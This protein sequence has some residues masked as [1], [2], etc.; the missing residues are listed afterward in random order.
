MA[1]Q[2]KAVHTDSVVVIGLGRFGSAVADSLLRLGHEVLGIDED[3]DVVQHWASR[4]TTWST[5]RRRW[6]SASPTWS[7]AG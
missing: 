5:R 1:K 4:L 3:A 7:R 2:H 6:A